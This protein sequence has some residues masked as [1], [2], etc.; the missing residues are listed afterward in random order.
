MSGCYRCGIADGS[1]SKLCETCLSHRYYNGEPITYPAADPAG[2]PEVDA[3]ELSLGMKRWLLSSGA[4]LY[5]GVVGLGARRLEQNR[6]VYNDLIYLGGNQF[7]VHYD[8]K[9]SFTSLEKER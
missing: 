6:D 1:A 8:T 2:S 5:I 9:V 7:P 3:P 4:V